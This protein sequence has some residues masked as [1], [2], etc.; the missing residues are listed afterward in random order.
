[1]LTSNLP[2]EAIARKAGFVDAS[3]FHRTFVKHYGCTPRTY[4]ARAH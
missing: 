4:R 2:I 1:L 3:H